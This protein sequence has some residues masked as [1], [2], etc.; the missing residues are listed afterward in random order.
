MSHIHQGFF[1]KKT[2]LNRCNYLNYSK[3]LSFPIDTC[4]ES[5]YTIVKGVVRI[6]LKGR[7]L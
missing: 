5:I 1:L 4:K 7:S 6:L 3:K 2:Q